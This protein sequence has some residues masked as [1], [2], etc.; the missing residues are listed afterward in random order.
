MS[1]TNPNTSTDKIIRINLDNNASEAIESI[2]E[3]LKSETTYI[4]ISNNKLVCWIIERF[5]EKY[6][7]NE[8]E[9]LIEDHFAHKDYFIDIL[10]NASNSDNI[11]EKIESAL[12][13][14]KKDNRGRNQERSGNCTQE[15]GINKNI[16]H[17]KNK[18]DAV[19]EQKEISI[20]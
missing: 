2:L 12:A 9:K 19:I 7:C 4:N 10:K 5:K 17:H 3:D 14:I 1:D 11:T 6:F 16:K 13:Q 15:R 18:S 20:S 8:K